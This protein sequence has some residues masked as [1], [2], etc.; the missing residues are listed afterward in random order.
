VNIIAIFTN[1]NNNNN[2]N[3]NN[4]N[5]FLIYLHANITAQGPITN[6][7]QVKEKK[8]NTNKKQ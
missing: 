1:N 8:Q 3:T 6:G 7:A 4:N 5:S 2:N